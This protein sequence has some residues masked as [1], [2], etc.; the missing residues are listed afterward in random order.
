MAGSK[1]RVDNRK[2]QQQGMIGPGL[3]FAA[4]EAYKLLRTNLQFSLPEK[5]CLIIGVTSSVRGEGKSTTS[6]N[7]AY[8]IAQAGRKTLLIDADMRL[9]S[10]AAKMEVHSSPGLSNL[11]A[12]LGN[13][14][15][16]LRRS[17]YFDNWFILPAGDIPPNPSELLGSER[18]HTLLQR[19]EE[20]FDV[21]VIDLPPI[22]IVADALVISK[23]TDGL[24]AVVRQN[25]TDRRA[26]ADCMYQVEKLG[27]KFLG[28]V[29]TDAAVGE[30]SYKSYKKYGKYG[31]KYGYG[32]DYGYEESANKTGSRKKQAFLDATTEEKPRRTSSRHGSDQPSED[33]ETDVDAAV[34]ELLKDTE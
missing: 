33:A 27:A 34:E 5:K 1:K 32:Y 19:Y 29:M 6:V 21:I 2:M 17:S 26:L 9:P 30:S 11:I 12:G 18:M 23:W 10:V 3:S 22:N 8:T 4:A 31:N 14:Q 13:E 15:D 25:Y 24:V 28:F 16:C 20:V 7:L